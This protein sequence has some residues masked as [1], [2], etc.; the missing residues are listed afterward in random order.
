VAWEKVFKPKCKGGMGLQDP[1]VTNEAYGAKLWWR[2]VKEKSSPWENLWK[3]K[4]APNIN[5]QDQICFMGTR[6]GSTIWNLAWRNKTWIQKHS[7]WEVRNG[8]TTKLWEDAWQQEPIMENPNREELEQEI[9]A[10]GKIKIHH[11]WK[12][13]NDCNKWRIWDKLNP[14]NRD[15]I[16]TIT[17]E[18]E[19]ELG[20]R[21]IV[22]EDQLRWGRKNGGEFN[23]KEA[24]NY[25]AN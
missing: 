12:Q 21:K 25:I 1:Q 24:Q 6:E 17:K 23:L 5:D 4:Y 7:F 16:P 20:K 8:K 10:Q 15:W 14:Q 13:G 19:E 11:Y 18:V 9:T 2:W 22:R 3:A